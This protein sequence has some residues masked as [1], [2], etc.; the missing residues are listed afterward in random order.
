VIGGTQDLLT[1]LSNAQEM[2][3]AIGN[4]TLLVSNHYGHG[5]IDSGS[6]CVADAVRAFFE[7]G[8]LP[9]QGTICEP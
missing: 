6:A 9:A 2:A 3:A 1:P 8:Q 4:A 7:S 5:A